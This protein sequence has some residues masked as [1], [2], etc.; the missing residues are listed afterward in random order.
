MKI[1]LLASGLVATA[2]VLGVGAFGA[3]ASSS[4]LRGLVTK[5]PTQPVCAVEKPCSA[6]AAGVI[7]TFTRAGATRS[8]TTRADGR[9]SIAL[10]SGSYSVQIRGARFGFRPRAV[11]VPLGRVGTANFSFDTGIR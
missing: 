3:S 6:P 2:T 4:G 11:M 5:S 9:Y 8:A 1:S 7:I 10:H